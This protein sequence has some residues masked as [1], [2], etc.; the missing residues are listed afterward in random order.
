MPKYSSGRPVNAPEA[1]SASHVSS[2]AASNGAKKSVGF[3]EPSACT[4]SRTI[5]SPSVRRRCGPGRGRRGRAA[6]AGAQQDRARAVGGE[7]GARL[8]DAGAVVPVALSTQRAL[9]WPAVETPNTQPCQGAIV[10]VAAERGVD[11]AFHQQQAGAL[12]LGWRPGRTCADAFCGGAAQPD[13]EAGLLRRR[14]RR[15]PRPCTS[16]RPRPDT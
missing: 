12:Q 9:I 10:A 6:V 7:P 14:W 4:C 16:G 3:S 13:G 11:D 15:R 1:K 8:P 2:C 5:D